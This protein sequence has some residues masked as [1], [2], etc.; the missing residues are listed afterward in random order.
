VDEAEF[1]AKL[2]RL[3]PAS[4]WREA[5]KA[6]RSGD[7]VFAERAYEEVLSLDDPNWELGDILASAGL[8][9]ALL[10]LRLNRTYEAVEAFRRV[11]TI[12]DAPSALKVAAIR[13]L[14]ELLDDRLLELDVVEVVK[15]LKP[16]RPYTGTEGVCRP[17]RWVTPG[18][19]F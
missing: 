19:S 6:E 9:L 3:E 5:Q 2:R 11:T 18:P 7:D 15:L 17:P 8:N 14:K 4:R 13:A 12:R 1:E 16:D 10:L